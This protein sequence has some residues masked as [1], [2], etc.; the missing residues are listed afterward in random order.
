MWWCPTASTTLKKSQKT[1]KKQKQQKIHKTQLDTQYNMILT[2]KIRQLVIQAT[3]DL[4]SYEWGVIR[5][6]VH[7]AHISLQ[8]IFTVL[9]WQQETELALWYHTHID[10][11]LPDSRPDINNMGMKTLHNITI[12]TGLFPD[13]FQSIQIKDSRVLP[14]KIFDSDV[15]WHT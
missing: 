13:A 5:K 15:E 8:Q 10:K 6:R 4:R 9:F 7:V 11:V 12:L 14:S 1:N 3:K 2:E